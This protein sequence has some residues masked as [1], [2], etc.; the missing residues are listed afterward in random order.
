M[1]EDSDRSFAPDYARN[2]VDRK[3]H[4]LASAG[5]PAVI[6]QPRE[7]AAVPPKDLLH[8]TSTGDR[9]RGTNSASA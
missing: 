9:Y 7:I 1:P 5:Q 3:D 6:Q 4:Q 2:L 8:A